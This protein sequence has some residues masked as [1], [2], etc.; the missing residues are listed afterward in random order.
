MKLNS[1]GVQRVPLRTCI[2]C[3][4][5]KPQRE[6][7]RIYINKSGE[8]ELDLDKK[9]HGRGAYLCSRQECWE[10]GLKKD[11]IE[12]T[13]KTKLTPEAVKLFQQKG[14]LFAK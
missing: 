5:T 12:Y 7:N 10:K 4:Q 1:A 9:R 14:L 8:L 3:R 2:G 13:L 6:L 11:R